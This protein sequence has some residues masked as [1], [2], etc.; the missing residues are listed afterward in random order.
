MK[1][2]MIASAAAVLIGGAYALCEVDPPK[3][4]PVGCSVWNVK[5]S[6]KTLAPKGLNVKTKDVCNGDVTVGS[7]YYY[8]NG[9]RT[10]DGLLWQCKAACSDEMNFALWE[11]KTESV[12]TDLIEYTSTNYIFNTQVYQDTLEGVDAGM[13]AA[14][15]VL[16]SAR[17]S[18]NATKVEALWAL[19]YDAGVRDQDEAKFNVVAAG[20]GA[21]D[22]KLGLIKSV[23]GNFA[24][25]IQAMPYQTKKGNV[26]CSEDYARTLDTCDE[27]EDW[28][29]YGAETTGVVAYGTW[30]IKYNKG[31]AKKSLEKLIPEFVFVAAE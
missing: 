21:Y 7:A 11:K 22:A 2:L 20:L 30:S 28:I 17:Y 18:K 1:K 5:F 15:N 27:W 6:V 10:L 29:D 26:I 12:F 8:E 3:D 23:S 31:A 4:E 16:Y 13:T 24:G 25:M 14:E 19:K 9:S